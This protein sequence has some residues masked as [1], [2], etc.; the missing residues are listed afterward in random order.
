MLPS[1]AVQEPLVFETFAGRVG[2]EFRVVVD[3]ATI[4][5]TTLTAANAHGD[6]RVVAGF[7]LVFTGPSEPVLVQRTYRLV[8]DE[9]GDLDIFIVPIGRDD[10]GVRYEAVFN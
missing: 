10:T 2:Q 6:G 1:A 4:I 5:A 7:S 9:L 8:H 3:A